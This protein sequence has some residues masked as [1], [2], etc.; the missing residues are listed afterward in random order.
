MNHI[1]QLRV[2]VH[3]F[4]CFWTLVVDTLYTSCKLGK[5]DKCST[6][7]RCHLASASWVDDDEKLVNLLHLLPG[8]VPSCYMYIYI[9]STDAEVWRNLTQQRRLLDS[10]EN[11]TISSIGEGGGWNFSD[12]H[13]VAQFTNKTIGKH[14]LTVY[15]SRKFQ[16]AFVSNAVLQ[17]LIVMF[18][19]EWIEP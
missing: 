19:R 16:I 6:V 18:L 8:S 14:L 4:T 2:R 15:I 12:I 11:L 1:Y 5:K 7:L 10:M 9:N 3:L 17:N 13:H